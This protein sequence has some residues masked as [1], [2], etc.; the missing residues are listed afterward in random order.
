MLEHS[1]VAT[2][3]PDQDLKRARSFYAEKLRLERVGS[4]RRPPGSGTAKGTSSASVSRFGD[5]SPVTPRRFVTIAAFVPRFAHH[6][7]PSQRKV[8]KR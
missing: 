4:V 2:R 6:G 5:G 7:S 8:V 1:D 3:L